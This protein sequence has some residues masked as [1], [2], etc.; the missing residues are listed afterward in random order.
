[1][2]SIQERKIFVGVADLLED[3]T[4]LTGERSVFSARRG[5]GRQVDRAN[6]GGKAM[7]CE[8]VGRW[9]DGLN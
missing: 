8:T 9:S 2:A 3:I 4:G 7:C 6:P 1:M 5:K